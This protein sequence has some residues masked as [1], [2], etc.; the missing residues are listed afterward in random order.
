MLYVTT[1]IGPDERL[2]R[3]ARELAKELGGEYIPRKRRSVADLFGELKGER[4][5]IVTRDEWR[6]QDVHGNRFFFHPNMAALRIKHLMQGQSDSL[7][8]A[9]GIRPG[10]HIL[11]C[12]LGLAADSIVAAFAAGEEGRVVGLESEPVIAAI[13]RHGLRTYQTERTELNRAMRRVEALRGDYRDF[14]PNLPD[15]S[16][17]VVMFD[18]MFRETVKES[19]A[20]Q[21]L[22]PI[23]NPDPL[24][25]HSVRE[26]VRV[27]RRL[28]LLKERVKS[29]EFERLGFEI[30]R[31]S[32]RFAWGVIRKEER[33]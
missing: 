28:V 14:L 17:D 13:V 5:V 33:R 21:L 4:A 3:E 11:D 25:E 26:A 19:A 10:D 20:M 22:K 27:A 29:G 16:F 15:N 6:Y 8:E 31:V 9:A 2:V 23:A 30:T 12:T 24:D 18:P 32:S 1:S 7:V